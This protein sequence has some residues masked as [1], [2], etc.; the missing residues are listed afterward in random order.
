MS[1]QMK[2]TISGD[3]VFKNNER[4]LEQLEKHVYDYSLAQITKGRQTMIIHA[5]YSDL[6]FLFAELLILL[7]PRYWKR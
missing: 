6:I 5:P 4:F 1:D 2:E 3:Q 7:T